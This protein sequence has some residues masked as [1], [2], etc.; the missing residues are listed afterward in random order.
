METILAFWAG[1]QI[2]T[3]LL[4]HRNNVWPALP[5][6]P[7]GRRHAKQVLTIVIKGTSV[8]CHFAIPMLNTTSEIPI[9]F[10]K[11]TS[12]LIISHMSNETGSDDDKTRLISLAEAAAVYGFNQRYLSRLANTG[13]LKAQKIGN[14]WVT[15]PTDVEE[16]IRSR[17]KRGVY[18]ND[19]HLD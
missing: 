3:A 9:P 13:R 18:R 17:Q 16:F 14:S 12:S 7:V 10:P 6:P 5:L 2:A 4:L 15:T 11:P 19:V 1:N 8:T